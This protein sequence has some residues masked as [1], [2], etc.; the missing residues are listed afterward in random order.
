MHGD[1]RFSTNCESQ[2]QENFLTSVYGHLELAH[3]EEVWNLIKS[4]G[5]R[6]LSPRAILGDFSE[7][8]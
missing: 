8:L 1:V 6:I 7:I 3:R 2:F 4:I 5:R